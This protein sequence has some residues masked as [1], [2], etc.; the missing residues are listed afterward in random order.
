LIYDGNGRILYSG[1]ISTYVQLNTT[2]WKDGVYTI[3]IGKLNQKII[4]NH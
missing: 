4:I 1:L 2:D 3:K